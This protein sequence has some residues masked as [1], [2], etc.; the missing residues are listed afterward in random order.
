M[1]WWQALLML[2][3]GGTIGYFAAVLMI[4]AK[5]FDEGDNTRE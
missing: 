2:W 5:R 1:S 3:I 4:A